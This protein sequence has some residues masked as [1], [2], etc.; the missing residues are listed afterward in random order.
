MHARGAVVRVDT[1]APMMPTRASP[2]QRR[3]TFTA[4]SASPSTDGREGLEDL[5]VAGAHAEVGLH[6]LPADDPLAIDH[7]RRRMRPASPG[8]I[9]EPVAVDH[10]MV[11]IR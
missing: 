5:L 8:R 3:S 1:T 11:G 7:E 10:A 9:V 4:S 6:E 2:R